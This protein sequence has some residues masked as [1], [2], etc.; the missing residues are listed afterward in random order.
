MPNKD[1]LKFHYFKNIFYLCFVKTYLTSSEYNLK[2]IQN[3]FLTT[4]KIY[5]Y[6]L[7][8][9]EKTHF[10]KHITFINTFKD[11]AKKKKLF[12]PDWVS[13]KNLTLETAKKIFFHIF[14]VSVVHHLFITLFYLNSIHYVYLK[15]FISIKASSWYI[16]SVFKMHDNLFQYI[17]FRKFITIK[18]DWTKYRH[19]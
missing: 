5:K 3:I 9:H 15:W 8:T 10:K 14:L 7:E 17:L 6:Q 18:D 11:K 2:A 19:C 1:K 12:P 13:K 16:C 4:Y